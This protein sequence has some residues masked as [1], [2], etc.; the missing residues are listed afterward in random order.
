VFL[1]FFPRSPVTTA[2]WTFFMVLLMF[3]LALFAARPALAQGGRSVTKSTTVELTMVVGENKTVP[4]SDIATYSVGA[5]GIVDVKVTPDQASF[6]LVAIKPGVTSILM[7][8]NSGAE[9]TYA[10]TVH[11]R[12]PGVVEKEL[13]EL[14]QGYTGLRIRRVG[15]RFF[16]EG[17]V[18]TDADARRIAL[19]S[20]L[21]PGQV[22]SLV[23]VGSVGR[24]H[25][26]NVRVDFY[27]VQYD[28]TANYGVGVSWPSRFGGGS[29]STGYDFIGKSGSAAFAV[30]TPLPAL[31]LAQ[32]RGWA[33]VL[34]HTSV[35]TTSGS[36]AT[37][38]NGGEQNFAVAS[39]LTSDI[40]PIS[41]GTN[42]TVLPRFDSVTK[43]LEIRVNAV[44]SDLTAAG[45]TSSLPGKKTAKVSTFV[46]L[47]LGQGLVLSGIRSSSTTHSV[48][49]L[50]LLSQIPVLGVLFGGNANS[51][52]EIEGAVFVIPSIVESAPRKAHDIVRES[53]ESYMKYSGD[54]DEMASFKHA[55]PGF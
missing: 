14:L 43:E 38:D 11:A 40:K 32:T 28:K 6:V 50:P 37:F 54:I 47:K 52:T 16:V 25:S 41:F 26:I 19:I 39:G 30:N 36:E 18:A 5:Q 17:G 24:D 45:S 42:V 12:Q 44:V 8:K 29:L 10:I 27:F 23:V 53:L 20:A 55:V 34:K 4:A 7:I 46:H 2:A 15:P 3:V 33:K 35:V 21:Y 49:G 13:E 51:D 22:E 48:T 9:T 31:D 1:V